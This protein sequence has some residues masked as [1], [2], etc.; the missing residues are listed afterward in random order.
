MRSV[1]ETIAECAAKLGARRGSPASRIDGQMAGVIG[2]GEDGRHVTPYDSWLDTRCAPYIERMQQEA[3][4]RDRAPRP[5]ARRASTTARRSSGG[6][7]SAPTVYARIAAFVQPG[8]YAAMRLCGLDG[9]AAFIDT[10]YLHFSGFAD[11]ARGHVGCGAVPA[12]RRGPGE[13]AAHRRAPHDD[14]GR[15]DR[16]DG[17]ARA[18]CSRACRWWRA[19]ATRPPASWPAARPRSGICVDVAGTASVFAATT[20]EFQAR[21]S[22][23]MILGCGRSAT[24]GLWHPYAYINGGGMNLEWFKRRPG[25]SLRRGRAGA[26]RL[27]PAERHGRGRAALP[28]TTRCSSPTW[29]AA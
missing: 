9:A 13:A 28:R 14:G 27:R 7:T 21:R 20:A 3:G 10:S 25:G 22:S 19:A 24:P 18:A 15:A 8:G 4:R 5:A 26:A 23:G 11:N 17:A 16:G 1:C 6:S 12:L 2:V 29:P